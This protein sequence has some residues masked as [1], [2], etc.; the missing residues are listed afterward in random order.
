MASIKTF[1]CTDYRCRHTLRISES[2]PVWH[3]ETPNELKKLPVL[4]EAMERV[5]GFRSELYCRGC[6]RTLVAI[7]EKIC[8]SCNGAPMSRDESGQTC[9]QCARGTLVLERQSFL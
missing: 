2:F 7:S 3:P 8:S 9:P 1:R 4:A 5:I 6:K